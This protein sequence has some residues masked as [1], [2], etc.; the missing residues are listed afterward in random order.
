M[1]WEDWEESSS[2]RHNLQRSASVPVSITTEWKEE[3]KGKPELLP[4]KM[5]LKVTSAGKVG[6]DHG[7]KEEARD[8]GEERR[9]EDAGTKGRK[10]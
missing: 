5:K 8:G 4:S 2:C 6:R 9:G 1:D 10:Q 3:E 7:G